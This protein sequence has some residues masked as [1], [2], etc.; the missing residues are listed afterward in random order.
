MPA[1]WALG[2]DPWE[3]YRTADLDPKT[4]V[5]PAEQL[6]LGEVT[7]SDEAPAHA[8]PSRLP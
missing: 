2:D 6:G 8:S 7:S 4:F 1:G 3:R 5:I